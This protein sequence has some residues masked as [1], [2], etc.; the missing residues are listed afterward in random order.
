[1]DFESICVVPLEKKK[2]SSNFFVDLG[3]ATLGLF[4]DLE[5]KLYFLGSTFLALFNVI[6]HPGSLRKEETIHY[7]KRVGVDA[8]PIVGLISFLL[9]LIIAFMSSIQ[10]RQFGA[11]ISD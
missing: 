1:M 4:F 8:L 11:D 2:Q 5:Y 3:E 9:G 10:L 7:M 6:R